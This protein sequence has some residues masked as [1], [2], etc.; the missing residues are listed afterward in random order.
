MHERKKLTIVKAQAYLK[1]R[2]TRKDV[3]EE[4]EKR[5]LATRAELDMTSLHHVIFLCREQ[6]DQIAKRRQP[7]FIK[8]RNSYASISGGSRPDGSP[9]SLGELTRLL[10]VEDA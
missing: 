5:F 1:A 10:A 6:L 2:K 7:L 9:P 3:P 8:K 4:T